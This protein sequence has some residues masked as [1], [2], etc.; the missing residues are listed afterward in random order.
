MPS[1]RVARCGAKTTPPTT[2]PARIAG[3]PKPG[4]VFRIYHRDSPGSASIHEG[5]TNSINIPSLSAV[6]R[7][8]C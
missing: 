3:E 6:Y 2:I 7:D 5:A 4:G 8:F 1:Y